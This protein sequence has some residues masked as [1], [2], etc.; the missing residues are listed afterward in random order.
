[1]SQAEASEKAELYKK[2]LEIE[3][4]IGAFVRKDY[5]W[6]R[7]KLYWSHVLETVPKDVIVDALSRALSSGRYQETPTCRC[8]GRR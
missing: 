1:M 8:C 4:H 7:A 3:T 2:G 6:A 5:D